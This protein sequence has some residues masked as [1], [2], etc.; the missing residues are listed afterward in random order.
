MT[1]P[2]VH[3][4]DQ[5]VALISIVI[6][7][8]NEEKN[9]PILLKV[10][11]QAIRDLP[12]RFEIIFINDGSTDDT[13]SCLRKKAQKYPEVRFLDFSRNFG[14]EAATTAG[15]HHAKG[16]AVICLDADMQHPPS[17]ISKFIEAWEEGTEVVIGVRKNNAGDSYLKKLGSA[18]F[19][20][21]LNTISET[22]IIPRATDYRLLDRMVVDEFCRLTEHNRMTRGLIDWLGFSRKYIYFHT[23]KRLYGTASYSFIKL[24]RLAIKAQ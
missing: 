12:Y 19:Y 9:I 8:H 14:K 7:V 20:K 13:L 3:S 16:A 2:L 11:R 21:I 6:P 10:L 23:P 22:E 1:Y 5:D 4:F 17:L 18:L 15:F 24:C